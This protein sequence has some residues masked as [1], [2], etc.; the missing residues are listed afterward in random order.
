MVP[1][2]SRL[3]RR[4]RPDR[5]ASVPPALAAA[6]RDEIDSIRRHTELAAALGSEHLARDL[7]LDRVRGR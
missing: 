2:L 6:L 5:R 4:L 3:A 7:G 1:L